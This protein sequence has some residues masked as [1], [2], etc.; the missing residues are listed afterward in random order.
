MWAVEALEQ[1]CIDHEPYAN[2]LQP[3][4]MVRAVGNTNA[5]GFAHVFRGGVF[6]FLGRYILYGDNFFI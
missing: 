2:M 3:L 4:L 1:Y 6:L 5:R